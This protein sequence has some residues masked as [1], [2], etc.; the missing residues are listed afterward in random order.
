MVKD[1][2]KT[3]DML[4]L[5]VTDSSHS[6]RNRALLFCSESNSRVHTI[7]VRVKSNETVTKGSTN[8]PFFAIIYCRKASSSSTPD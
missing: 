1:V 2:V 4:V 3:A 5:M 7:L 8:L 6:C